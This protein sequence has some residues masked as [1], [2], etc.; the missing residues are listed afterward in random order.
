MFA[1]T[2]KTSITTNE[3][4]DDDEEDPIKRIEKH[5]KRSPFT[6]YPDSKLRFAWDLVSC[7]FIIH[8]CLLLPI[9]FSFLKE[10]P[11]YLIYFENITEIWFLIDIFL[12]FNTGYE[13]S[14]DDY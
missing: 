14:F 9:Q 2:Q 6:I 3:D 4:S 10:D 11:D 1:Q 5:F 13:I 8:C 12:N 7:F